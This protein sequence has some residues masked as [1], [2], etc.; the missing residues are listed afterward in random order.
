MVNAL[1]QGWR[2]DGDWP[3]K[4]E[5]EKSGGGGGEWKGRTD[6]GVVV[7]RKAVR[8]SVGRVKRVLGLGHG[9]DGAGRGEGRLEH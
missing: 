4:T 7:G 8:R 9:I 3:P 5:A 6:G 1:V 2:K